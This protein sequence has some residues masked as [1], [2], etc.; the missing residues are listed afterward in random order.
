MTEV[1]DLRARL[2]EADEVLRA[3]RCGE[4]DAVVVTGERGEQVYTLQGADCACRQLVETMS[5]G[6]ATLSADGTILY[7]NACLAQILDRPLEQVIGASLPDFLPAEDRQGLD[8]ILA[9]ARTQPCRREISLQTSDGTP[10]PVYLAASR[11]QGES[12]EAA[13]CVVLTDLTQHKRNEQVVADERLARSILDQAAEAI[14]VC[15]EQS[16]ILRASEAAQRFCEGSPLLRPFAEVFPLQAGASNPFDL[17]RVLQGETLRDVDVFLDRQGRRLDLI[18]NAGPLVSGRQILGSVVTLTDITRCKRTEEE[19]RRV[20][21]ELR[22]KNG[23][24]ERFH[25]TASH[26]LRSPAVTFISFL[27]YLE[28]DLGSGDAAG[29]RSDL[30]HLRAAADKMVV[31]LDD[32]LHFSRLLRAEVP[33]G[34]F[35]LHQLAREVLET[36]TGPIVE[37]A[38]R[39]E[40]AG[41]DL[42]LSGDRGRLAEI[43]QNLVENSVKFMGQQPEPRIEIGVESGGAEPLFYVRDNGIGIDARFAGRIFE[44]FEKLD[45]TSAGTGIGLAVV[46]RIVE[47][48]GGRIQVDSPGPGQGTCFRFTLP[49]A[50]VGC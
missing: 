6:A 20:S 45:A 10:F 17:A 43:W 49:R 28:Q 24:L 9:Q 40:M 38:V 18:L 50:L 32:L 35:T 37:R 2:A 34:R 25:Y 27:G 44:V 41:A 26:D 36:L 46:R 5:E 13:F 11:L 31:R 1:E 3:I 33:P 47:S 39:V 15:N 14:V 29:I 30:A 21:E 42:P 23:E 48:N 22:Q 16:L 4:V 12:P 7:C 8:A 19:Q